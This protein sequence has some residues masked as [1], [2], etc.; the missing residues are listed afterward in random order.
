MPVRRIGQ[1]Q[2]PE[3]V[4]VVD[5]IDLLPCDRADYSRARRIEVDAGIPEVGLAVLVAG[6]HRKR[7]VERRRIARCRCTRLAA[8][9]LRRR[10]LR[11]GLHVSDAQ[12][13]VEIAR[14]LPGQR[15]ARQELVVDGAVRATRRI[16]LDVALGLVAVAHREAC[17]ERMIGIERPGNRP[18]DAG[19]IAC[20]EFIGRADIGFEF[21]RRL[22]G[23]DVDRAGHGVLAEEHAL[24]SLQHFHPL[25]IQLTGTRPGRA[26]IVGAIDEQTHGLLEAGIEGARTH[27]AQI[28]RCAEILNHD[29]GGR[30]QLNRLG[31][32][33]DAKVRQ[34]LARYR[35][36]RN[37]DFRKP[38]RSLA[39]GH[40]DLIY[41]A[42]RFRRRF[43]LPLRLPLRLLLSLRL[44]RHQQRHGRCRHA[45]ADPKC[46]V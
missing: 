21:I 46:A 35:A 15:A 4:A 40:D 14:R 39:C 43:A 36:D 13:A 11:I 10:S 28:S 44:C 31:R 9:D 16:V 23:R 33:G 26:R 8:E 25:D 3:A 20:L 7:G 1:R 24:R 5:R 12:R 38:F 37:R 19:L 30:N 18:L 42:R 22:L 45:C 41:A 17:L 2:A 6:A 29:L 27:T 32:L 34:S